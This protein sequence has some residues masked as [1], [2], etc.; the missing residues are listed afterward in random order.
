MKIHLVVP[1]KLL[2]SAENIL[3]ANLNTLGLNTKSYPCKLTIS[4]TDKCNKKCLTCNIWKLDSRQ[5]ELTLDEFEQLFKDLNG[6]GLIYLEFTGGEPYLRDDLDE[7]VN[8]AFQNISTLQ[9]VTITTNGY[10]A[11]HII[12]KTRKILESIPPDCSLVLGVSIDGDKTLHDKLKGVSG[13]WETA[14]S[15]LNKSY[16]L[17]KE[18][19]N[20]RTHVSY[21]INNFNVGHFEECH[22]S[23]DIPIDDISFSV[24]HSGLLY[25]N[26]NK[27]TLDIDLI[28]TDLEYL[29][30][31]PRKTDSYD[32]VSL[33]RSKSY[34]RY[35][36]GIIP[37]ING[38]RSIRCA[39]LKLSGYIDARGEVYPCIMWDKVLGNVRDNKF[40]SLWD[41]SDDTRK[42]INEKTCPGCWT[43]CEVQPSLLINLRK[44][45][46]G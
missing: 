23:L 6:N 2:K 28:R 46:I 43:P 36:Q 35:V 19:P 4:V 7:L 41:D 44:L 33:F 24:Q 20:L 9:F 18:Y 1:S 31:N 16:E 10:D 40:K 29:K 21:T 11:D 5:D 42:Q 32:P 30:K 17:E 25:N 26:T 13:S 37:Y 38:E 12:S 27:V 39:A 3:S 8:K 22:K 45:L 14:S 34:D 15:T